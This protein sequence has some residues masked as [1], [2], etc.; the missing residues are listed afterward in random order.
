MRTIY[1]FKP[2]KTRMRKLLMILLAISVASLE[3]LAQGRTVTGKVTDENGEVL[4]GVTVT[5][6]GGKGKAMTNDAG[7]YSIQVG[8]KSNT[9]RFTFVGFADLDIRITGKNT[10]DLSMNRESNSLSEV[11]VVGYGVQQKKAFTGS[12]SKIDAKEFAQLVT[13]S[14]DRQLAGRAAGVQVVTSGGDAGTPARIRIRGINSVSGN[15]SPLIV[16]DGVPFITGNLAAATNSN[17]LGDV[18]PNDIENI[19]VLKDGSATAIYGSRAANGVILI[20]TKKGDKSGK[21]K[22]NYDA[23]YGFIS[24]FKTYDLLNNEQFVEIANEKRTNQNLGNWAALGDKTYDWQKLITNNNVLNMQQNLS[25]SG[26]T[27]KST[28]FFSLNYSDQKGVLISNQNKA[29]R[30]RFNFDN[31]INKFV[32]IG[33]NLTLSRQID[34]DQNNGTNALSGAMA[35]ALRMLPNVNPFNPDN[36]TGFNV[37]FPALNQV[38][39]GPNTNPVDDNY[40]NPAFTLTNNQY[41][42]DKLRVNNNLYVEVSPVK[43]LKIRSALNFDFLNDYSFI[44]WSPDHGDGFSSRGYVFNGSTQYQRLVWQNYMNYN[45][46]FKGGHNLYL[47]A[48]HEVQEDISRSVSG[49]LQQLSDAFFQ[50]K[51]VISGSGALQFAGGSYGVSGFHSL[52]G[53]LN[54]DFSSKYFIQGSVRRDGQSSLSPDNRYG[55]FPGGSAGWRISEE[56]FWKNNNFL[57]NTF[58]DVKLKGSYAVV[59]NQLG[60]FP[61]LSTFGS[62]PYGNIPGLA[63]NLIGN[64]ALQW[65]RSKKIDVGI[66]LTLFKSRL[67]FVA[68]WFLNDIDQLVFAVPTPNSAGIPGNSISQNI[69]TARNNGLELSLSGDIIRAKD[70]TWSFNANYTKLRNE[71]TSLYSI[72]GVPVTTI[73]GTYNRIEVG[74]SLNYLWGWQYMGVNTA[75]GNPMYLKAD[76]KLVQ[77]STTNGAY[78]FASDKNDATLTPANQTSITNDDK[79]NL[80]S[81]LPTYFGAFTNNFRYKNFSLE[82]MIRFQGGNKIMNITRQE[83]L[84]SQNFHNNGTEILNRWKNPGD[85]TD[86]PRLRYAQSATVNQTGSAISRFIENGDYIRLQNVVL[87]YNIGSK[88]LARTNGYIKSARIFAQGQNL[89]TITKYSGLDPDNASQAGLDNA[90]SPSLRILAVGLSVGF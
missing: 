25:F 52:F 40:T 36:A 42:S 71:I 39:L 86:V 29:Y 19:E 35:S 14:V 89:L 8:E 32:K 10:V 20:T 51:N 7:I 33:N 75:T 22:I 44:S 58:S 54:Y 3:L 82:I 28:Y 87:N 60:G 67:T 45:K 57:S 26:G 79:V 61:Y 48:G 27:A 21:M 63:P 6:V 53:R 90:V 16:V 13:P 62:A 88:A 80:G 11:V 43:G 31:E 65:E 18:N 69:G 1:Q 56:G 23:T 2:K 49:S 9:L 72:G 74:Q 73:P 4:S 38:G 66:E 78:Y 17:A 47:T 85:V 59:G 77:R 83:A 50:Q 30:I 37:R 41:S 46:S 5:E 68:D 24:P 70:F 81:S 76:G 15:Q 34:N 84:L 12:A 64:S 55:I